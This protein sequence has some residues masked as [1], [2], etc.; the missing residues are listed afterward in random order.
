MWRQ[1]KLRTGNNTSFL[2][3]GLMSACWPTAAMPRSAAPIQKPTL[4]GG[5][6]IRCTSHDECLLLALSRTSYSTLPLLAFSNAACCAGRALASNPAARRTCM[7][8]R[9]QSGDNGLMLFVIGSA[10]PEPIRPDRLRQER[11]PPSDGGYRTRSTPRKQRRRPPR[12]RGRADRRGTLQP[13]PNRRA[14][15]RCRR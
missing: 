8:A 5:R 13:Q 12:R 10:A 4:S 3:G 9:R 7:Y 15:A 6:P 11:P 1:W 14:P 2:A